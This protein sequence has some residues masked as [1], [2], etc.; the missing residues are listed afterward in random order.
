MV[1]APPRM[2][3]SGDDGDDKEKDTVAPSDGRN[4][5]PLL[6][7]LGAAPF[8]NRDREV[9]LNG[10][11]ADAVAAVDAC[12]WLAVITSSSSHP[13]RRKQRDIIVV[14]R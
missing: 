6:I 10:L 12:T 7:V 13:K 3:N 5:K 1:V 14:L 8:S 2:E 9:V 4:S 11:P